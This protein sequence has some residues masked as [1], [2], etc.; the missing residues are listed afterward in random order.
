MVRTEPCQSEGR[1]GEESC[2]AGDRDSGSGTASMVFGVTSRCLGS[3]TRTWEWERS[4][5]QAEP[6]VGAA[7]PPCTWLVIPAVPPLPVSLPCWDV[8]QRPE[9]AL[10]PTVLGCSPVSRLSMIPTLPGSSKSPVCAV[11]PIVLGCSQSP[12]CAMIPTLLGCSQSPV[13][14]IPTVLGCSQ[15]PS[16][17]GRTA[18]PGWLCSSCRMDWPK[19]P[20]PSFSSAGGGGRAGKEGRLLKIWFYFSF[21][22]SDFVGNK[23]N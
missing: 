2:P 15:C 22:C 1:S 7:P 17:P 6:N 4:T 16:S 13:S 3:N 10:I 12:V 21:S 18:M 8:S 5:Q 20:F 19:P 11:I 14:V 9:C 23:F